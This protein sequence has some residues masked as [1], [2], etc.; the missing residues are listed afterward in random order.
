MSWQDFL[1]AMDPEKNG[2][3]KA[4]DP[5]RNGV[6][7]VFDPKKNGFNDFFK[8]NMNNVLLAIGGVVLILLLK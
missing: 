5:K 7:D 2:F 1:D 6:A 8:N 3:N 4:M